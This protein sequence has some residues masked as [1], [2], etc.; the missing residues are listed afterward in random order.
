MEKN[1]I[2]PEE[3]SANNN[4]VKHHYDYLLSDIYSWMSGDFRVQVNQTREYFIKNNIKP[5]ETH[6]AID[7]GSGHGIQS[8][9]LIELGF[10]VTAVDQSEK[11]L[12]ELKQNSSNKVKTINGDIAEFSYPGNIKPE[13]IVC[14]GDT[15]T[16]LSTIDDVRKMIKNAAENLVINGKLVLSF[17]DL[18]NELMGVLRVIPVKS[19]PTRILTCFLEFGIE[20]VT[21]NDILY[22]FVDGRWEMKVSSY[23]KLKLSAAE[24]AGMLNAAGLEIIHSE[25]LKGM[26][27][28]IAQKLK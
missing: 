5:S 16:H 9:A 10:N 4:S 18:S 17:R 20:K 19:E 21:V 22:E 27:F 15:L 2:N 23:H 25:K 28:I 11:L 1:E 26:E 14:M 13:L 3:K 6:S 24:T 7:L 8:A 12:A